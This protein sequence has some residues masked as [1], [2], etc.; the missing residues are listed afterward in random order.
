VILNPRQQ[1]H[2]GSV[3]FDLD[4]AHF[5]VVSKAMKD[6][7]LEI[8]KRPKSSTAAISGAWINDC[9]KNGTR[10]SQDSYLIRKLLTIAQNFPVVT[11]WRPMLPS[12]KIVLQGVIMRSSCVCAIIYGAAN[13]GG[14]FANVSDGG[15]CAVTEFDETLNFS[16]NPEVVF[17]F[18]RQR[19][20][21]PS[22]AN[23]STGTPDSSPSRSAADRVRFCCS[24]MIQSYLIMKKDSRFR[25]DV[26]NRDGWCRISGTL[27]GYTTNNLNNFVNINYTGLQAAHIFPLAFANRYILF[28]FLFRM[29]YFL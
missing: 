26:Q 13:F 16:R 24:I 12:A 9:V 10:I 15:F 2:G 28:L 14:L 5:A 11:D 21:L 19:K 6:K 18:F 20:R 1:A 29:S 27:P 17:T 4:T 23:S 3:T 7:Q 8:V 22:R 25:R